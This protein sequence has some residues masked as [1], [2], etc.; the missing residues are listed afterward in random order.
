MTVTISSTGSMKNRVPE[1]PSHQKVPSRTGRGGRA[2]VHHDTEPEGPS[3]A[4]L[5]GAEADRQQ[6]V[7]DAVDG[8]QSDGVRLQHTHP[9]EL[10]AVEEHLGEAEVVADGGDQADAA[11]DESRL[12]GVR[13]YLDGVRPQLAVR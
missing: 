1:E 4:G 6:R 3:A 7:G 11:L 13:H 8:H 10:A 5:R 9:V 2:G 12:L